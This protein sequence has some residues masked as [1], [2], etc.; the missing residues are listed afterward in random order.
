M[1]ACVIQCCLR[2]A[3]SEPQLMSQRFTFIFSFACFPV[4]Y[5]VEA[6]LASALQK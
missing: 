5:T 1:F 6:K 2:L 4:Y 3:P